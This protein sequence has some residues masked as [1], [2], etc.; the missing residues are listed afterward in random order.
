MAV[1]PEETHTNGAEAGAWKHLSQI[2]KRAPLGLLSIVYNAIENKFDARSLVALVTVFVAIAT[3]LAWIFNLGSAFFAVA[4]TCERINVALAGVPLAAIVILSALLLFEIAKR[5]RRNRQLFRVDR[6]NEFK[7]LQRSILAHVKSP[8]EIDYYYKHLIVAR[9]D[10]VSSYSLKFSWTGRRKSLGLTLRNPQFSHVFP[11]LSDYKDSEILI[12]FNK[13]LNKGDQ[14]LLEY[15]L[16][17]VSDPDHPAAPFLAIVIASPN[18]PSLNTSLAV[19]FDESV[20]IASVYRQ[21]YSA[22]IANKPVKSK[23]VELD[24]GRS[25]R[26]RVPIQIGWRFVI[27][28]VYS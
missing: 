8:T 27:R 4:V 2:P 16:S 10:G 25:H 7:F 6:Q 26:W 28:W 21:K 17:T 13:T 20:Q 23:V 11:E 14:E 12:H 9:R 22:L 19:V 5:W 24:A 18:Y 3:S 15:C 1:M